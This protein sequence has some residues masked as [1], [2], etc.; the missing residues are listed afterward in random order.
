[1]GRVPTFARAGVPLEAEGC[2]DTCM[3]YGSEIK[4]ALGG[5]LLLQ[6]GVYPVEERFFPELFSVFEVHQPN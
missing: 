1:M 4:M 2:G 3:K 5:F 6:I